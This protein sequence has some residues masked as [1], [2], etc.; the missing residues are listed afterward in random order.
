MLVTPEKE[1]E[2]YKAVNST[3]SLSELANIIEGV[4]SDENGIILGRE[5]GFNAAIMADYCRNLERSYMHTLTRVY[6]IRQQ[7]YM[8]WAQRKY[9]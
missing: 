8:L 1:L 4:A 2:I 5:K 7:A 3:E 6:G 9:K